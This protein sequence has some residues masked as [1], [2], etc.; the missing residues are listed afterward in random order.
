MLGSKVNI[1]SYPQ[2]GK[3][4]VPTSYFCGKSVEEPG[5]RNLEIWTELKDGQNRLKKLVIL[6]FI[7]WLT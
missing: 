7:V 4:S 6:Y 5:T 2:V 3:R 1:G